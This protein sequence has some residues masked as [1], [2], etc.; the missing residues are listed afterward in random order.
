MKEEPQHKGK[1]RKSNS[2]IK[3]NFKQILKA[4]HVHFHTNLIKGD[5]NTE[6]HIV[7]L[8][9]C[10]IGL[11]LPVSKI[12]FSLP[13]LNVSNNKQQGIQLQQLKEMDDNRNLTTNGIWR[14]KKY[15]RVTKHLKRNV[16]AFLHPNIL[17]SFLC[18]LFFVVIISPSLSE[19]IILE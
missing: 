9:F 4:V 14:L 3:F 2:G 11:D 16:T 6:K 18:C 15:S 8:A 17:V 5:R 1:Q 13:W 19:E 12:P 7:L 10:E